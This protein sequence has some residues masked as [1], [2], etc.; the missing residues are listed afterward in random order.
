MYTSMNGIRQEKLIYLQLK[1]GYFINVKNMAPDF[2]T[3][4][5]AS[6]VMMSRTEF[7]GLPVRTKV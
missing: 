5:H 1:L 2:I 4:L 7:D 3:T 6:D